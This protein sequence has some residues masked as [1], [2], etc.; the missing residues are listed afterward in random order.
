MPCHHNL[1]EH[2]TAYLGGCELRDDRR[3]PLFRTISRG[4]HPLGT[5][6]LPEASALQMVRRR[7]AAADIET[8]IGNHSFRATGITAYATSA[9]VN[10]CP[11]NVPIRRQC[12]EDR[13]RADHAPRWSADTATSA[14][15]APGERNRSR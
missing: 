2:L 5:P 7:A 6:P 9:T 4:T 11:S 15:A 8:A 12:Y 13:G 1:E 3:G 10:L 14:P